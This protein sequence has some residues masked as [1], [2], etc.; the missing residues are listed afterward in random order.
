MTVYQ[1]DICSFLLLTLIL[2]SIIIRKLY[3]GIVHRTFTIFV[4]VLLANTVCDML[5]SAPLTALDPSL[6]LAL[7]E[8]GTFLYFILHATIMPLFTIFMGLA[9]GTWYKFINM[10]KYTKFLFSLPYIVNI[11]AVLTNPW[12][13]AIFK[14]VDGEYQR[15]DLILLTY[16]TGFFYVFHT[17]IYLKRFRGALDKRSLFAFLSIYPYTILAVTI[18]YFFPNHLLE[19]FAYSIA[20][21]TMIIFV[22]RPE[23]TL[24]SAVGSKTMAA[25]WGDIGNVF[26]SE[27]QFNIYIIKVKSD[28]SLIQLYGINMHDT[29]MRE[30]V[31]RINAKVRT[32]IPKSGTYNVYYL[33]YGLAAVSVDSKYAY[34]D[35]SKHIYDSL[36]DKIHIEKIDLMLECTVCDVA[37][38]NDMPTFKSVINFIDTF[39][40]SSAA[41][42][43]FVYGELSQQ[44]KIKMNFDIDRYIRKAIKNNGFRMYYQPIYSVRDN[45]F[46]TAEALIRLNDDEVGFISPEDFIP[47]AEKSGAIYEIGDFVIDSVF[48]FIEKTRPYGVR[49]IEINISAMQ[50]MSDSFV[51]DIKRKLVQYN[52]S[53]KSVNF[54]LTE[55]ASAILDD[56]LR[57]TVSLLH[58]EG[59]EFSIDDYGTGYSN[60]H[61][62]MSEPIKLIKIDRSLINELSDDK[63]RSVLS[64]T[65]R[66]IKAIGMEIVAEG[67]ETA[68]TAQWLIDKGCDYIQGYYYAKPMP[69]DEY[70]AF[71]EK[72]T[73][74]FFKAIKIGEQRL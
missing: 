3:T 65:I 15:G 12:T 48:N 40:K 37:I 5:S 73:E 51:E 38:P 10:H 19:M 43:A 44:E 42:G 35:M 17:F 20:V 24:N 6:K 71:L 27:K 18:Q 7:R 2:V 58:A 52:V 70:L 63:T 8:G 54:E 29:I 4:I 55:S 64:D 26:L 9:A 33:N 72:R 57:K 67:V 1:Y 34:R 21:M 50:C 41:S 56:V 62:I 32:L 53:N 68:E 23:K 69:E 66:M 49:Y 30:L 46:V 45:K 14:I 25:F 39:E 60:L 59:I 47:A 13:H 28:S 61:R 11:A 36:C 74:S 22:I 16:I 31:G